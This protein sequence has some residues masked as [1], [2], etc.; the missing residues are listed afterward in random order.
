M[1]AKEY[2]QEQWADTGKNT[3]EKMFDREDMIQFAEDYFHMTVKAF[4]QKFVKGLNPEKW[5]KKSD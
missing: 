5:G 2:M 1:T 4:L 3:D